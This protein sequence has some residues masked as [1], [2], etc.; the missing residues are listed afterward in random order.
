MATANP[1][2]AIN[3]RLNAQKEARW[4]R[5][6]NPVPALQ[7]DPRSYQNGRPGVIEM[8][9][10][11]QQ[12]P[13]QPQ[14][15]QP[16]PSAPNPY[17]QFGGAQGQVPGQMQ[18]Y[19][20][21]PYTTQ[22]GQNI[23]RQMTDNL[24]RNILPGIGRGAV[25]A[26][27]YGGSRQGIAEGLAIGETNRGIGDAL[28]NLYSGQF[29]ADRNYGLSSDA[30]DLNVYNT[31]QNWMRQGQ[32]DQLNLFDKMLGWNQN[33]YNTATNV[34]NTPLNYYQQFAN[35]GQGLAGLGSQNTQNM[36]GNPWLGAIGGYQLG[37][38]MFKG[39]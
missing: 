7:A 35:T 30:L 27:G 23:Q 2:L 16:P 26:G 12:Q 15:Q 5:E 11:M 6:A 24:Q 39:S 1:Y 8:P 3:E 22:M 10:A 14:P 19:Q 37:S 36:Q 32:Q 17:G 18:Q 9:P 28:T 38:Q 33:A 34:Q 29:N 25:A 4:A 20:P 31:N 13:P 21:N